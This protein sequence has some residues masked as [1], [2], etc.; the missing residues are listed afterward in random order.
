MTRG[1]KIRLEDLVYHGIGRNVS[2]TGPV[3]GKFKELEEIEGEY[4][5]LV[6]KAQYGNRSRTAKILNIDRKTLLAKIKKFNIQF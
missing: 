1:D 3:N 2:F 6:L 5:G 4:I